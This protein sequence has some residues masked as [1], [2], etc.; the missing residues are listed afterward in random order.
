MREKRTELI[1][2]EFIAS[3][4][5]NLIRNE[6][7]SKGESDAK[8]ATEKKPASPVSEKEGKEYTTDAR[9]LTLGRVRV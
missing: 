7:V 2:G 8:S 6:V 1:H 9:M 5:H 4:R 3:T